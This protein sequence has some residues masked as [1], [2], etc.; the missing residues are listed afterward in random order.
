MFGGEDDLHMNATG[1][2]GRSSYDPPEV[3]E[4]VISDW[5]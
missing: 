1:G 2:G 4:T 3:W 5:N